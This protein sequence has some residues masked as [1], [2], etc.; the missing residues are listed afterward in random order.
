VFLFYYNN[1]HLQVQENQEQGIMSKELS[2]IHQYIEPEDPDKGTTLLLHGTGAN[3][4][5]LLNLG[6][7]ITPGAGLLSPRGKILENGMYPRFFRRLEEGVFDIDNLLE[8]THDLAAFIQVA[9]NTYGFPAENI[10]IAGFSNGA[11]I[12]CSLL[13]Q[14]PEMFDRAVLLRPM[15]PYEPE[16]EPALAGKKIF[17]AAG[18][19]D[20]LIPNENTQALVQM[21]RTFGGEVTLEW[22]EAGHNLT[23]KELTAVRRWIEGDGGEQE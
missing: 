19:D 10:T 7:M 9:A 14:Y 21:L 2:F 3:E 23:Q 22:E 1:F 4:H 16:T 15:V 13:M 20:P 8:Q 11:N 18:T 5:D 6:R 12:G 17:V